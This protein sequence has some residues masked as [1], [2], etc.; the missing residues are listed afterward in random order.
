[1]LGICN[2]EKKFMGKREKE[3]GK[4]KDQGDGEVNESWVR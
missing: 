3:R 2:G 1:M 4:I